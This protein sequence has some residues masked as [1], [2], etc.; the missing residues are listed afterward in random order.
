[1]VVWWLEAVTLLLRE[2]LQCVLKQWASQLH[3]WRHGSIAYSMARRNQEKR[4]TD[5]I[6]IMGPHARISS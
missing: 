5:S 4:K 2:M 3:V 1:M 6:E